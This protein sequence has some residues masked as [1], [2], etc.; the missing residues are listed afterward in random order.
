[1]DLDH[2]HVIR[3]EPNEHRGIKTDK[4]IRTV[5]VWPQL[6][7]ILGEYLAE[8]GSPE[9]GLLFPS[10]RTGKM[11]TDFRRSLDAVATRCGFSEGEV[12]IHKLR[13]TYCA[14]RI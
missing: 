3:I 10:P 7:E 13:H 6:R 2:R 9:S 11:I 12:R 4:S 14:A 8:D 1:M 5:P